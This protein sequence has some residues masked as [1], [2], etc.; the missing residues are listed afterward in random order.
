MNTV[1]TVTG[2][3][4][5]GELGRTLMHEH[6]LYGYCGYQG[7]ATLGPFDEAEALKTCIAAANTAKGYGI[8]TIVDATTNE[9][10]RNVRF[11]RKVSEATGVNIICSTGFYFEQESSYAYWKFRS[12]FA[13]ITAEIAEMMITELTEGI[14]GTG[15]RAGVIKL[16]S[17]WN[18]ITPM[19][20]CFFEA[21]ARAQRETGCVIITHTQRGTMGPEQAELLIKNGANPAKIAIGHMCGNTDIAYHKRVLALGVFVNL[22]RFGLQGELFHTPTDAQRVDLIEDI[23]AA[24]YEDKILLGHDSV[25]VQLGRPKIMTPMLQEALR[26]A[27]IGTIGSKILPELRRRGFTEEQ[28]D[29]LLVVNPEVLFA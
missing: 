4:P 2:P 27:N 5:A 29:R 21:A 23:I 14:E 22:D 17:S 20:Q 11:L 28:L 19:E 1:Q 24:G 10:G 7:D 26:D 8:R 6:F 16:G 18:T 13:D 9:C 12:A 3:V 15:I 25:N